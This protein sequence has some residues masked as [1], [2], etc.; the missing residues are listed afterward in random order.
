MSHLQTVSNA[1]D[2][3]TALG[4]S[5]DY[6]SV[7]Q[8]AEYLNVPESTT[9]RLLQTLEKKGFVERHSRNNIGLGSS[10]LSLSRNI[11]EKLDKEL[12][13]IAKP[14]LEKI[15]E[16]SKETSILS[17][18]TD[19]YSKCIKSVS[20]QYIIRFVAENDRLLKLNVGA[21]SKAILAFE[22]ERVIK[23]VIDTLN[24]EEE[25]KNLEN[26][27]RDIKEKGY[28]VS[29]SEYDLG[30][31][32]FGVPVFNSL[33]QIYASLAIVG[34]DTRLKAEDRDRFIEL[35]QAASKDITSKLR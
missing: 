8:L 14:W 6:L 9:Y 17:I 35:L 2:I 31:V 19:I 22:N 16:V 3:L 11:H 4:K 24:T 13:L 20:S 12:V 15:T 32:G 33:G 27:L 29:S 1:L 18:R 23:A 26:E 21:S 28:A 30:A 34:P 5:D 25:R 10:L 7:E